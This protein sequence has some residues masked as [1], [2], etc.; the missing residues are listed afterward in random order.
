MEVVEEAVVAEVVAAV[1]VEVAE[2]EEAEQLL[3]EEGQRKCKTTR[4]RTQTLRR[5]PT[6]R[7]S[8]PRRPH[9]LYG[10]KL[11]ESSVGIFQN[12]SQN[13]AILYVR[14]NH[15]PL[16]DANARLGATDCDAR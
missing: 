11:P 3:Q 1:E 14:G 12:E 13:G 2:E 15:S 9:H 6:R 10:P 7:R 4:G 5:K 8:I 16:E